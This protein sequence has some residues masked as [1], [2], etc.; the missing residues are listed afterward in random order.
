MRAAD[1]L[2]KCLEN[3]GVTHVFGLSGE[4]IMSLLD[5]LADSKI[6]PVGTRHEQG[7]ALMADVYGRLTGRP[8]V[9]L[10]T[11]G[12]GATNLMTGVADAFLDRAPL[13]ATTGQLALEH[14]HKESHQYIDTMGLFH[15]IV[16]WQARVGAPEVTPEVIRKAFK[17]AETEKPGPTHIEIADEVAA[18][19]AEGA[20]LTRTPVDYPRPGQEAIRRAADVIASARQPMILAGNGVIRRRASEALREF[21]GT[22]GIPVANTFMSKG[23]MGYTNPLARLTVG[24]QNR[25]YEMC[26]LADADVVI[27]VG[28]DMVEVAPRLW[29]PGKDKR[30][31][32]IDTLPAEVD[33][34][35]LPAV[36]VISEIGVAL[37]LLTETTRARKPPNDSTRL[38]ATVLQDWMHSPK[39]SRCQ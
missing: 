17:L 14:V 36:E 9:C 19:P 7:A 24:L 5:A 6:V 11:L 16:K 25:D 15:S 18:Q 34:H 8:G 22:V 3:E 23:V 37:R 4:E 27:T 10:A 13:V 35:Y 1:L 12:P 2:V 38:K 21:A 31:V 26:G 30:I 20:P 39:T 33:E 29:N 28:Y 32:H